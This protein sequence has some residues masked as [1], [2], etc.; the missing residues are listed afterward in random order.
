M[1]REAR[2]Q[3]I[4]CE[5]S[6]REGTRKYSVAESLLLRLYVAISTGKRVDMNNCVCK[7]CRNKY[8][9]WHLSMCGDFDHIDLPRMNEV[10]HNEEKATVINIA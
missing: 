6:I 10:Q 3:C 4:S 8:D 2:L 1:P 7:A 5:D 9:R